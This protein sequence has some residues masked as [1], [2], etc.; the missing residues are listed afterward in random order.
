MNA[1]APGSADV[2][3]ESRPSSCAR[4]NGP[5]RP[6]LTPGLSLRGLEV[7]SWQ[8]R[9]FGVQGGSNFLRRIRPFFVARG[10]A[11]ADCIAAVNFY[12]TGFRR[13]QAQ[14]TFQ[15][16]RFAGSRTADHHQRFSLAN[17]NRRTLKHFFG[18]KTLV[19]IADLKPDGG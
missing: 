16:H 3:R 8:H 15:Q 17:I 2:A 12:L 6:R 1:A 11:K 10:A 7:S 13:Q 9:A 5:S 4:G 14:N 19:Q 18:P